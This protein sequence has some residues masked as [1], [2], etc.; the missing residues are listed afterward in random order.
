MQYLTAGKTS[1]DTGV[2]PAYEG[3]EFEAD[4]AQFLAGYA[5]YHASAEEEGEHARWVPPLDRP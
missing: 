1:E 3:P 5:A 4:T 2:R